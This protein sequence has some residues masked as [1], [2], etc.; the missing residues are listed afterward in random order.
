MA[1]SLSIALVG[2]V[3]AP[4]DERTTRA[5]EPA[6]KMARIGQM[7]SHPQI[8]PEGIEAAPAVGFLAAQL[9]LFH[10]Q[11]FQLLLHFIQLGFQLCCLLSAKQN[12]LLLFLSIDR[13]EGDGIWVESE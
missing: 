2:E 7:G 3:S 12:P 6:P 5:G 1:E 11:G 9:S 13:T 10:L 4:S 8:K